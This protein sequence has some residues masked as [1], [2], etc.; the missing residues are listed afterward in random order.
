MQCPIT[1]VFIVTIFI[2]GRKNYKQYKFISI[3]M[4]RNILATQ[5]VREIKNEWTNKITS[6]ILKNTNTLLSEKKQVR[7]IL[8]MKCSNSAK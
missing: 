5:Y 3:C 1:T 2:K 7:M 6:T 8:F 4:L